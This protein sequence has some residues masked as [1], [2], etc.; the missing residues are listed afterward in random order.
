MVDL[1]THSE[2]VLGVLR[3]EDLRDVILVGQSSGGSVATGVADRMRERIRRVVYVEGFV[4]RDGEAMVDVLP[5]AFVAALRESVLDGYRLPLPFSTADLAI[6]GDVGSW[7][8]GRL[9][10]YPLGAFEQPL[11]LAGAVD[12]LS[13]SYVRCSRNV[14][15]EHDFTQFV[16]RAIDEGWDYRVIDAP[17]DV[18]VAAPDALACL[19]SEIA[20]S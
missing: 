9:G 13:K 17:H 5:A 10:F 18:Q 1:D 12:Q 8:A 11:R 19:L 3:Y 16:Q 6:E 4:L 20:R 14:E 7:Y 15:V 2:D